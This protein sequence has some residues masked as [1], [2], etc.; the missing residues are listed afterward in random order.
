MFA[1][2]TFYVLYPFV[3]YPLTLPHVINPLALLTSAKVVIPHRHSG[4]LPMTPNVSV[5]YS[6]CKTQFLRLH[7]AIK[8]ISSKGFRFQARCED[9]LKD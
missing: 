3:T 9:N 7:S 2:H 1:Y 5:S 4:K 6:R 8:H